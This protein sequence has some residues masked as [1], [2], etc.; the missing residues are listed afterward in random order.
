MRAMELTTGTFSLVRFRLFRHGDD[1]VVSSTR[2]QQKEFEEQLSKHLTVKHLATLG[3]CTAHGDVTEVRI[4]NRIVRWAQPPYGS[5]S[6]RTE[7]EADPRHAELIMHQLGLSRSS[8]SVSTPSEKSK[9]GFDHSTVLN[10]AD[11]TK[12]RSATMRLCYP[13]LDRLDLQFPSKELARWMQAPTVGNLEVLKRVAR[14]LIGRGRL[15]Q[16]FVRQVEERSHVVGFTDSNHAGLFYGSHMPGSTR[17]TQG[18]IALNSGESEFYLRSGEGNVS[19]TWSS[20]NAQ[21]LES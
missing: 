8:R 10:S 21:G 3:P 18:V 19:R 6:A 20:L 1:F 16:E 11:H 14:Y 9:L 5:G 17:T 7:Y 12:Y 13:A 4:L 15:I 2:T